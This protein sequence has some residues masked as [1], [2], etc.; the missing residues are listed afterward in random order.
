MI[1]RVNVVIVTVNN[2]SPIQGYVHPDDHTEPNNKVSQ[3][4]WS[5]YKVYIYLAV[6]ILSSA[7]IFSRVTSVN[8]DMFLHFQNRQFTNIAK[9][10]KKTS[11]LRMNTS[12][13]FTYRCL[14]DDVRVATCILSE[15]ILVTPLQRNSYK[16][17]FSPNKDKKI[18]L[19]N[20]GELYHTPAYT[21]WLLGL[22]PHRTYLL[23]LLQALSNVYERFLARLLYDDTSTFCTGSTSTNLDEPI[24]NN[25]NDN[26]SQ[27]ATRTTTT[28]NQ[29]PDF[30]DSLSSA[31]SAGSAASVGNLNKSYFTYCACSDFDDHLEKV[32]PFQVCRA[33]R[34]SKCIL[35][36]LR[37]PWAVCPAMYS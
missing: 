32:G 24:N 19:R 18:R 17:N 10:F 9:I 36:Y 12:S 16:M 28:A 14:W 7:R 27:S 26:N 21:Q 23:L 22:L 35:I 34:Y 6:K 11:S 37:H 29:I 33:A 3:V 31:A 25:K 15:V 2:N 13:V 5:T 4:V 1:V 8:A 20:I 30:E